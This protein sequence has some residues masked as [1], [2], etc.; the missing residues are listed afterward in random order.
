[1]DI[2]I[3]ED[4]PTVA[5][6]LQQTLA[7]ENYKSTLAGSRQEAAKAMDEQNFDL[8]LLDWNLPDGDGIEMM[9]GWRRH[10]I[11]IPVLVLSANTSVD[12]RVHALNA[13]ADDY[14]CKPYSS[15]EL[16]ARV[17]ALLRREAPVKSSKIRIND[18]ELDIIAREVTVGGK[19][20]HLSTAEFDLLTLLFRHRNIVLTRYQLNE[21]ICKDFDRIT[22]SN[23]IDVHIR[24]I[25]KKL[26][27]PGLIRTVRGVGY[28]VKGISE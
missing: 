6:Q 23:L 18:V 12:D 8:I 9:Q 5:K 1:M 14:L 17:R 3:V 4:E 28:T 22:I 11:C 16:L 21:H 25:R 26:Q 13:G 15:I 2:L 20:V 27:R 24:N 10:R 7:Q 19:S